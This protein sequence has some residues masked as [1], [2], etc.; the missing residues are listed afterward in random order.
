MNTKRLIIAAVLGMAFSNFAIG[1]EQHKK[2]IVD[3]TAELPTTKK[4]GSKYQFTILKDNGAT[5][6]KNQN[7]SG[8]CWCFSTQSFLESEL[9]RMGKGN[10]GLSQMF[11]VHGMYL[12]KA[13]NYVRYQGHAQFGEG[14]RTT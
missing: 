13:K 1:Q 9:M 5:S 8:T 14:G 3:N 4:A 11:V 6:V 7:K 10:I 12:D 2:T